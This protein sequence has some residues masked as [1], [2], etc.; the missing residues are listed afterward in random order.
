[1]EFVHRTIVTLWKYAGTL[2][3]AMTSYQGVTQTTPISGQET[4]EGLRVENNDHQA[5]D[6]DSENRQKNSR[7][8]SEAAKTGSDAIEFSDTSKSQQDTLLPA[9]QT[10]KTRTYEKPNIVAV[11]AE[12]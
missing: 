12:N 9:D 10:S 6:M 1:M 11:P 8:T 4:A 7:T 5:S 2:D 3:G